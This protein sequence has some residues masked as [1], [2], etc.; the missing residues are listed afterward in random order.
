MLS[1]ALLTPAGDR[2]RPRLF[3]YPNNRMQRIAIFI[4]I[5][6]CVAL[7]V[8]PTCGAGMARVVEIID[9]HT[10]L[11]D[12]QGARSS[13]HLSGVIVPQADES[14]AAGFLRRITASGWVLI[15]RDASRPGEAFLFRSPDGLSINGEMIRAAYLQPGT[16]M[17]Y[18]GESDPGPRH[19]PRAAATPRKIARAPR[20]ARPPRPPRRVRRSPRSAISVPR[21]QF[22][23]S[24]R[25]TP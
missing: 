15:E 22:Q 5:S 8:V 7:S 24:G 19:E 3:A 14:V 21:S 9:S 18:L 13:V 4:V 23:P 10:V 20:E 17:I 16:R 1:S 25:P 12:E 6:L 2:L 11:T